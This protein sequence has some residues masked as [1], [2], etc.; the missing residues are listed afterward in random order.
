M[1]ILFA[2]YF[3]IA[4]TAPVPTPMAIE[5]CAQREVNV[6]V[7]F[8]VLTNGAHQACGSGSSPLI[9]NSI[10]I[11]QIK[12]K[13]FVYRGNTVPNNAQYRISF[14]ESSHVPD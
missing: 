5:D 1:H 2:R 8:F 4:M 6:S 11:V 10:S 9:E 3:C 7:H 13:I 12:I 14:L